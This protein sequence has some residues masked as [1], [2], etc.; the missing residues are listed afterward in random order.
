MALFPV[1]IET[2]G[3]LWA[4]AELYD[5]LVD[6]IIYGP[7]TVDRLLVGKQFNRGIR[8]LSLAYDAL[9]ALLFSLNAFFNWCKNAN[10]LNKIKLN[11]WKALF[12]CHS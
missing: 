11:V 2:V 9:I 7:N 12:D 8:V 6:S 1:L 3:K 5:L 10:R 4:S